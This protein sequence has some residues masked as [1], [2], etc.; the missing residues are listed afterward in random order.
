MSSKTIDRKHPAENKMGVMPVGKLVLSMSLPMM[1]SMLVLALYNVVDS[2]F[3]SR[4]SEDALTAVSLAFP[5]QNLM[6]AVATGTGVGVNAVLSKNLGE[7]D[8]KHANSCAAHAIVLAALS[9]LAFVLIGFFAVEPFFAT[10]TDN[11]AI[12]AYGTSYLKICCIFSFGIFLQVMFERLLQSTG[13]TV[14]A[15]ISQIVGAVINIV[16]DPILIFGLCGFPEMGIAGAAVATVGGQIVGMLA[17]LWLSLRYN[18]EI[19]IDLRGFRFDRKVVGRIYAVGVPSIIMASVGSVMNYGMNLIL[20]R[21]TSTAAAVFGVYFKLQSFI[22]MPVFGLNNGLVP[23]VAYNYGAK[24]PERILKA[25]WIGMASATGIMV[26][27][28]LV[29]QLFPQTL[30]RLFDASENMLQIGAVALRVISVSFLLAG[31][32]AVAGAMFQAL[33][34]GFYSMMASVGRQIIVLLPAAY[35][36]SLSGNLSLVWWAFP[37][38]EIMSGALSFYYLWRVYKK[39]IKPLRA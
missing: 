34:K 5:I 3:V 12:I 19:S 36:L 13:K 20:M 21:F 4:I 39:I 31:C 26:A 17:A 6:I 16:M 25:M 23:I 35:L 30:L 33:G 9:M 18:R 11:P 2:V 24:R 37:I 1:I 15:M 10:Q 28:F 27:G 22:F 32:C 14:C 29:A 8:F 38:A 7:R